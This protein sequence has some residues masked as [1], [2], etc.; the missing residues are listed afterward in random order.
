[1]LVQKPGVK[2]N[3]GSFEGIAFDVTM[4]I[5]DWEVPV[6]Q[7]VAVLSVPQWDGPISEC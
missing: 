6:P 7:V 5:G 1:M 2:D 3:L 4:S